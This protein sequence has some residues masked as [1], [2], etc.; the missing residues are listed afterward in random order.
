[1]KS[2]FNQALMMIILPCIMSSCS[3]EIKSPVL[4]DAQNFQEVVD[5]KEVNLYTLKNA[6]G[7]CSQITNYGGRIVNLWVPDKNGNF[8]DVVLG[9]NSYED[10]VNSPTSN[11]GALIGRFAN[12]IAKGQYTLNDSVYQLEIN[13]GV[14]SLHGGLIGFHK[15][16]WDASQPDGQSLELTYLSKDMESGFPGNLQVKVLYT[17]TDDN[18]LKIEYWAETDKATPINLTNHSYFNLAG[19]GAETILNQQVQVNADYYTPVDETLIPTGEIAPVENTP[20]DFR[21][22]TE[23]DLHLGDDFDQLKIGNGYDHNWVLNANANGLTYAAKVYDPETGRVMEVYTNEPGVQFYIGNFLN[24][25]AIGKKG[26]PYKFRSALCLETQHYPDSPN[27][28]NFPST[29]LEPGDEFYSICI[30][31][32]EV[33]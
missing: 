25:T 7:L 27:H 13:N 12:R 23:I 2:K 33:E 20:M 21:S 29:I 28:E 8:D 4:I 14:N 26:L 15:V 5:G 24:G 19:E 17:L 6:N 3:Q 1:M 31:K 9:H 10:Y 30:Y 11:F 22:L 16:V 32:F 18:E